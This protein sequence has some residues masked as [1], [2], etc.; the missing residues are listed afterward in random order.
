M[1]SPVEFAFWK[2]LKNHILRLSPL[3]VAQAAASLQNL[4]ITLKPAPDCERAA[5]RCRDGIVF[6]IKKIFVMYQTHEHAASAKNFPLFIR[7]LL[8]H[9]NG[10]QYDDVQ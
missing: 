6:D 10:L 8:H 9:G 3:P 1:M 4:V 7:E 5:L 2:H